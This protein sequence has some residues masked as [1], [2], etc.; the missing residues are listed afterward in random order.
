MTH[1]HRIAVSS[2]SICDARVWH[3]RYASHMLVPQ[4][5]LD[6]DDVQKAFAPRQQE[7]EADAGAE[8]SPPELSRR[9]IAAFEQP[10]DKDYHVSCRPRLDDCCQKLHRQGACVPGYAAAPRC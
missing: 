10:A 7:A 6:R 2:D 3:R 9:I 4:H 1:E 5:A 8:E